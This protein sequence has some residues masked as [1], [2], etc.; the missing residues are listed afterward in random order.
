[1]CLNVWICITVLK[2]IF[3]DLFIFVRTIEF[4]IA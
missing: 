4:L 2:H 1:M 3:I